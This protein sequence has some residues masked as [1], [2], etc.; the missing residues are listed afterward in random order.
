[1]LNLNRRDHDLAASADV[2]V[3][4]AVLERLRMICLGAKASRFEAHA[5]AVVLR[6]RM[7]ACQHNDLWPSLNG[8]V[9]T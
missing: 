9:V 5:L 8:R 2:V 1:M 7:S 6:F 3:F 4:V